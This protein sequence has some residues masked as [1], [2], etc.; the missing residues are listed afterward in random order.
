MLRRTNYSN[1][2]QREAEMVASLI[3][4]RLNDGATAPSSA[5]LGTL[6]GA[7]GITQRRRRLR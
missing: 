2:Q 1:A 4:A 6:G 3:L 5:V 7:L